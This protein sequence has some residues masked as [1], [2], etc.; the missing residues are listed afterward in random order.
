MCNNEQREGNE[1]W[2]ERVKERKSET[3]L[4]KKDLCCLNMRD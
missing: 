4:K 1:R 2:K 3:W